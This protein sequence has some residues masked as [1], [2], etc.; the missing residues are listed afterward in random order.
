MNVMDATKHDRQQ[1]VRRLVESGRA[2]TQRELRSALRKEGF[3]AD[4]ST[5]SRDLAELNVRKVA[6]RYVMAAPG[7]PE[8]A[9]GQV[10]AAVNLAA[11]VHGFTACGPH[12]IVVRT[13]VGQAQPVSVAIDLREDPSI[14]ATLA[15]DDAIFVATRNRRTQVV[16]LRRLEQWFG[17]KHEQ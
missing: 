14:V 4:Q 12:L 11:A 5:L 17:E 16:A 1:H 9:P 2:A 7:S 15:G 8:A 6:G 10:A 13:A 3:R